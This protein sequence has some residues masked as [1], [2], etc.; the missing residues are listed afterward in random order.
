MMNVPIKHVGINEGRQLYSEVILDHSMP[1]L[2]QHWRTLETAYRTSPYFEFYE[3]EIKP[4]YE[5]REER[6]YNFNLRSIQTIMECLGVEKKFERTQK[7]EVKFKSEHII[8]GRFLVEAKKPIAISNQA[9][10]Q[11]FEDRH[12]FV[13]NL[14]ILDL[15]FNEGP[16]TV[17]YLLNQTLDFL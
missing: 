12:G 6:L 13:P 11:V 7:Y 3:D 15:L 2:K 4:L 8:D 17:E 9:Y 10:E 1:W 14:S 16:N 5:K